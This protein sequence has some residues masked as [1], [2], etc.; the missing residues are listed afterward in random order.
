S[1]NLDL[2]LLLNT[3]SQ[4]VKAVDFIF[5]YFK[6]QL[7]FQNTSNLGDNI[8][9]NTN[10]GFNSN[11]A[12]KNIDEA[13]SK[14]TLGLTSN[15]PIQGNSIKLATVKLKVKPT[16]QV[17]SNVAFIV[18]SASNI[19]NLDTQ[20]I[21]SS[22]PFFTIYFVSTQV[23]ATPSPTTPPGGINT[24]APSPTRTPT[25]SRTPTPTQ[26]VSGTPQPTPEEVTTLDLKLKF[27]GIR[28]EP[29]T[30][31]NSLPVKITAISPTGEQS[32]AVGV[33]SADEKGV[34][35][36]EKVAWDEENCSSL[37]T[38][39]GYKIFIK[40]P[41]HLQ[42]RVCENAPEETF[43]GSYHCEEGAIS[44]VRGV[45]ELDFSGIYMLVG[46]LPDQDGVVNSYDISLVRNNI[47]SVEPSVL[48]LADLNLDGI[49]DSQDYSL[50]IAAL[51]IRSDEG[52]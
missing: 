44:L 17:G 39:E 27:Q 12:I 50:V 49:V 34:W 22:R 16:V 15:T 23:T 47:G 6:D 4:Q 8:V 2:D 28:G 3:G 26:P 38:G 25:P 43:P 13:Q 7:A 1:E 30:F 46:D 14:I 20:N 41:K 29:E 24:P 32:C 42:K 18:D 45:N 9:V 48:E 35:S 31:Y 36:M 19:Y 10:S 33:F 51:S 5:Y 52:E 11:F 21:L 37:M 40:G